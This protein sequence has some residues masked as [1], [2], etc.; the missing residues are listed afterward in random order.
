[1]VA[2]DCG[3]MSAVKFTC[4]TVLLNQAMLQLTR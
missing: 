3:A 1:V 4:L 2:L